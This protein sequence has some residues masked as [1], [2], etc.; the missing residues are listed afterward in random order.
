[1]AV[2]PY[3]KNSDP[4]FW[5][6]NRWNCNCGS[7]ALDI[8]RCFIPYTEN[9][10]EVDRYDMIDEL[11]GLGYSHK[12]VVDF[13]LERDWEEILRL[14]DWIVPIDLEDAGSEERVIAYRI[15]IKFDEED[16][17]IDE[18]FHFRVRIDGE[19]L[20]KAG[21]FPVRSCNHTDQSAPWVSYPSLVYD[22]KIKY[23]RFR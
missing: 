15:F 6:K 12:E 18:D 21:S 4:S 2:E 5:T 9:Y 17:V 8:A 10:D 23:A 1:M 3:I 7:F 16:N 22:S 20:E 19:W 11:L 13:V 14:C